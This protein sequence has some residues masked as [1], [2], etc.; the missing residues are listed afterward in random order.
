MS[1]SMA[2]TAL[3][4]TAEETPVHPMDLAPI[5]KIRY[6]EHEITRLTPA[7]TPLERNLIETYRY[8]LR[9]CREQLNLS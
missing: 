4:Y 7:L 2:L 8:L 9:G 3:A 6:Y 1:P 5:D